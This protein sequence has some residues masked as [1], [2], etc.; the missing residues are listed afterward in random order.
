MGGSNDFVHLNDPGTLSQL[1]KNGYGGGAE[2]GVGETKNFLSKAEGAQAHYQG[3]A[4][5]NSQV[6]SA[7][8][9]GNSAHLAKHLADEAVRAVLTE[10]EGVTGDEE[11]HQ[12]QQGATTAA[13]T[14]VSAVSKPINI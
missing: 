11:A 4:G 3:V 13:E 6:I 5:N 12:G 9:A 2:E 14:L 7:V 10:K 1:G 8:T